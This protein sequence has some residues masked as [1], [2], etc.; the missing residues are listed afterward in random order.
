MAVQMVRFEDVFSHGAF[1]VSV[2]P[3]RDFERS[4]GGAFVQARDKVSSELLWAVEVFDPDP[5]VRDKSLRV[6]VAAPVEPT[7]P[8]T[9][10]G[11]PFRAWS[12]TG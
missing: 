1:A 11:L 9:A 7:L 3:V 10:P 12:S 6:K 2:A 4:Q 8:E 5:A